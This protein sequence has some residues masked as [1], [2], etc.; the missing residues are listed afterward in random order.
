MAVLALPVLSLRLGA[1]DQGND[2]ATTTTRKAYDLLAEG[3]GP[4]FNGPLQVVAEPAATPTAL[5]A[6]ASE[7]TRRRRPR[8]RRRCRPRSGVTVIQVVPDHLTAVQ[9]DRPR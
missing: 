8:S 9:G 2:D 6:G 3:F 1:T 4:G 5:G 7:G